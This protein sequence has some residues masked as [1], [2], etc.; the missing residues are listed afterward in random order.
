M[1]IG[2][3]TAEIFDKLGFEKG[4]ETIKNAGFNCVDFSFWRK[5]G[6]RWLLKDD[7]I[8]QAQKIDAA[9]KKYGL[10]CYQAHAPFMQLKYGASLNIENEDF[11]ELTRSIE[12]AA[13]IGAKCIVVHAIGVPYTADVA[14][15]NVTFYKKLQPFAEK[16]NV[17]IAVENL[18]YRDIY[19]NFVHGIFSKPFE[20][21][22]F[23]KSLDSDCFV[24]CVD[25]GHLGISGVEPEK[26][27]EQLDKDIIF[28]LHVQDVDF[29]E[30]R[31]YAPFVG[32]LKWANIMTAL[33]KQNYQG[34]LSLELCAFVR[35]HPAELVENALK[36]A[37]N[38]AKYMCDL[39][40][41]A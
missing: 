38:N 5:D 6:D 13:I 32:Q 20:M 12:A 26:Y 30:D 17:K 8:E 3:D 2:I 14:E 11:L 24:V 33:K 10:E 22:S 1:K 28:A 35:S 29:V 34:V 15:Y 19:T 27:I 39:F 9:L 37:C 25:T 18:Y 23:I 31:H 16:A 36:Y 4:L 40:E 41:K 7:Y 21:N